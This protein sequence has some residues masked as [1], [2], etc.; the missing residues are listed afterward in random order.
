MRESALSF[1]VLIMAKLPD[2]IIVGAGA[3]GLAAAAELGRAGVSVSVLEARDR[4][5]GRMFTQRDPVLQVPI[6]LGAEF[7]HGLPPEIWKPL[8]ERNI[9]VT[10]MA[11]D[12]WC[13]RNGRLCGCDF[14]AQVE[15][16]LKKMDASSADESFLSFL[17]RC[18][19]GSAGDPKRRELRER[20][21]GYVS[22]YNA[23]DPDKVGVHWLID[24]MR[25]EEPIEGDRAFRSA[26]GYGDLLDIFLQ[27]LAGAGVSIESG[28]VVDSI[29]WNPGQA[30]IAAHRGR[31]A[32]RFATGKVLVT[33]PLGVLKAAAGQAG[34]VEFAPELPGEKM[35][36]LRKLEMGHAMR[37]TLRFRQ[38]FWETI[39]PPG[40]DTKTLAGMS[41][42]FSQEEWYPTWWT[43][44]PTKLPIITG[45]APFSCAE[46]LA[47][48]SRA[49]VIDHA[50]RTLGGLLEVAS[51]DLAEMLEAAYFYDWQNDP[52]SRGAYSY[53]AV[54]ADGAQEALASPLD[55]TLFF[56]GEATDTTGHNGTVHGAI[57]SGR[58]AARELVRSF[59]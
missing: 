10:E 50:L 40:D 58:R 6:E 12:L 2:V 33:L 47:G 49:F 30:E 42:L 31:E 18:Y 21:L 8:Q 20:V 19:P 25:A 28:T 54:G 35:D 14:F 41:F 59:R 46:R 4:V 7:I 17:N 36:A 57:A 13:F 22:G 32:C 38:R 52:F 51:T 26:N 23:A 37:I 55:G 34:T 43:T 5:G 39:S 9:T 15:D 3:A 27:E 53:G 44:M 45:W 1:K 24:G 48:Q 11:G 16:I 56:A 29:G